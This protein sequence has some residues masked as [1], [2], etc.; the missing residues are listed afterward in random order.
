MDIV[1]QFVFYLVVLLLCGHL[2]VS[3][4]Y[5]GAAMPAEKLLSLSVICGFGL[6][7]YMLFLVSL[8][9]GRMT[10]ALLFA[11]FAGA[12]AA[13]LLA[14]REGRIARPGPSLLADEINAARSRTG[15][16]F[17]PAVAIT[18]PLVL[19][20][21]HSALTPLYEWDA[22]AIW[23]LKA[24]VLYHEGLGSG[25][26]RSL[27]LSYSHLDYPLLL[28]FLSCGLY[29]AAGG[30]CAVA[31]KALCF[32]LFAAFFLFIYSSL[33]EIAGRHAVLLL[34]AAFFT[35]P[36]LVRWAG[37]GT[38]DFPLV[39]YMSC[40]LLPLASYLRDGRP[41][42]LALAAVSANFAAF[43]KNEGAAFA[44]IVVLA[45]MAIRLFA[46]SGRPM[47]HVIAF[48]ALVGL[49]MLPWII[50]SS[51]IPKVHENY[52][53]R[54]LDLSAM[55]DR[56]P[57]LKDVMLVFGVNLLI[58]T[59]WG[60]FWVLALVAAVL[61]RGCFMEAHVRAVCCILA[62]QL[63]LYILVFTVSPRPLEYL[64]MMTL[65]RVMMHLLPAGLCLTAFGL[66]EY[67]RPGE[68]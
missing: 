65:D 18:I 43:T 68:R 47:R 4:L 28:P 24:K 31:A 59:K 32:I 57:M 42:D 38:A 17:F 30:T 25:Y 50:F 51:G 40:T 16:F 41:G 44:L 53:A 64:S 15:P 54:L 39:V 8:C 37:A 58:P 12:A 3:L 10:A 61:G 26:F 55:A 49:L 36:E 45:V 6:V 14:A 67:L 27:P 21:C 1:L 19:V 34:A 22:F 56:L 5:P 2:L 62:L 29:A 13:E 9:G 33:R 48:A 60:A 11:I 52:G 35:V 46:R 23:D 66:A 63:C 20:F 7:P